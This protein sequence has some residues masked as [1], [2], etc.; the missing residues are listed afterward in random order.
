LQELETLYIGGAKPAVV[1]RPAS[2]G[3]AVLKSLHRR[4]DGSELRKWDAGNWAKS[5][6]CAIAEGLTTGMDFIIPMS[7]QG[8]KHEVE[9]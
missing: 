6:L 8:N 1:R 2:S 3:A 9:R 4:H 7:G 5:G